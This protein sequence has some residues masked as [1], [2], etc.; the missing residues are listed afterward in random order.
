VEAGKLDLALE[1]VTIQQL[2][3]TMKNDFTTAAEQKGLELRLEVAV[4]VPRAIRTDGLRVNQI[5]RN[6]VSNALKFTEKG[7][8][9][10]HFDRIKEKR[11]PRHGDI[12]IHVR[13]SGVGIPPEKQRVIFD[14]FEQVDSSIS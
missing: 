13:D 11:D 7:F 10:I 6:L 3:D 5:L 14:A 1:E 12:A 8:V 9:L 2:A 4:D